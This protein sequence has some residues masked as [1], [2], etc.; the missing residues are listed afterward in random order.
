MQSVCKRYV[1]SVTTR[2]HSL[3]ICVICNISRFRNRD[4]RNSYT[5]ADPLSHYS[6]T[7][8][9]NP[10]V[11][12]TYS[13]SSSPMLVHSD[14]MEK[15]F[16]HIKVLEEVGTLCSC[17]FICETSR[18]EY[19]WNIAYRGSLKV[20]WLIWWQWR[21]PRHEQLQRQIKASLLTQSLYDW[22]TERWTW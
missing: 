19:M 12:Y 22:P 3:Y 16:L 2:V 8:S 9:H 5:F 13:S 17:L 6:V 20:T 15:S 11:L 18:I 14:K 1:H 10:S 7:F 21:T 4:T